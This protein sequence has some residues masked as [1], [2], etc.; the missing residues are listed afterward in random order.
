MDQSITA[1]NVFIL[2]MEGN[3]ILW[4]TKNGLTG[5]NLIN[6]IDP[7]GNYFIS[8]FIELVRNRDNGWSGYLSY[9]NDDKNIPVS[10]FITRLD[11]NRIL[12]LEICGR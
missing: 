3:V 5:V 11:N 6:S 2:D 12:G 4:E 7:R 10:C 9:T 1:G 8:D